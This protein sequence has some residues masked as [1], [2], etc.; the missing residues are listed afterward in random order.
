[1]NIYDEIKEKFETII[2]EN[3]LKDHKVFVTT[4][5]LSPKEAIGET[6]RKDFPILNGKEV[7]IEAKFKDSVGQAFTASPSIYEGTLSE[8]LSLDLDDN[9]NKVIFVS[10]LNAV[11]KHLGVIGGTI[12]CKN[13]EPELCGEKYLDYLKKNYDNCKIALIGFQPSILEHIKDDF[14]VR[15]L[16][17]NE[18][19]IGKIKYD[20]LVEHGINDYESV[21]KWADI[22]LCTGSTICNGSL[23]NFINLDKEVIFYGTTLAGVAY[24]L[25]LK[26]V[27][28]YGK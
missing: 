4:K 15:V 7:M 25:G 24:I 1:M 10:T 8:I 6:K 9:Y 2:L 14:H 19:N 11:L 26:R 23:V 13:E 28:F 20:T 5:T 3:D 27:C 17:L 21:V 22:I 12:H 18:D 16:D